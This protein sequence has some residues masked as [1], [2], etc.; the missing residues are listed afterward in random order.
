MLKVSLVS[1]GPPERRIALDALPAM[2]GRHASAEIALEDSWVG[3]FQCLLDQDHG[4]LRVLDL[5]TRTGTFV[6]GVRI[7]RA[8]LRHGDTLTV[9]RTTFVVHYEAVPPAAHPGGDVRQRTK[10]PSRPQQSPT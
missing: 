2:I 8:E 3:S 9:G 1:A 5:G 10:I 4:K 7:K 6:N